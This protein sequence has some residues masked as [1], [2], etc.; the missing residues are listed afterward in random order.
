MSQEF[1]SPACATQP[2]VSYDRR[3]LEMYESIAVCKVLNVKEWDNTMPYE[4]EK[5]ISKNLTLV[6]C[7]S[8]TTLTDGDTPPGLYCDLS[9]RSV[10]FSVVFKYLI[11]ITTHLRNSL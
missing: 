7:S 8:I 5:E 10:R 3:L 2:S 11:R 6:E 9:K 1:E 4:D